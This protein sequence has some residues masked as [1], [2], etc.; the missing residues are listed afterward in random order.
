MYCG[1]KGKKG[2]LEGNP[3]ESLGTSGFLRETG[4]RGPVLNKKHKKRQG[5]GEK[6]YVPTLLLKGKMAEG[7]VCA[8]KEKKEIKHTGSSLIG[9]QMLRGSTKI[10]RSQDK[11]DLLRREEKRKRRKT[12]VV[13]R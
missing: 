11:I 10:R 13:G 2:F 7:H 4:L 12:R 3:S 9:C 8:K 1:G 6:T 5:R